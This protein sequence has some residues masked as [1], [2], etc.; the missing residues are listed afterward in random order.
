V[1]RA[2]DHAGKI[3]KAMYFAG[4]IDSSGIFLYNNAGLLFYSGYEI[5]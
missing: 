5:K 3:L 1:A 2:V 4:Y